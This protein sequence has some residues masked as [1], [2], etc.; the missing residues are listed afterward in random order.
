MDVT[1]PLIGIVPHGEKSQLDHWHH[2]NADRLCEHASSIDL[3]DELGGG[4]VTIAS[5]GVAD[6]NPAYIQGTKRTD[7]LAFPLPH[8]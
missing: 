3:I 5:L 4:R 7:E 6:P 8:N 1:W 2:T